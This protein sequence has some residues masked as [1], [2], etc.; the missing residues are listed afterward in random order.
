MQMPS[1]LLR[2]SSPVRAPSTSM[3][4]NI[5]TW[6]P[7]MPPH[8]AIQLAIGKAIRWLWTLSAS[9]IRAL[10]TFRVAAS[11]LP[12]PTWSKNFNWLMAVNAWLLPPLG[13]IRKFSRSL[14]PIRICT[15]APRPAIVPGTWIATRVTCYAPISL[16][17]HQN[18]EFGEVNHQVGLIPIRMEMFVLFLYVKDLV[19]SIKRVN[20]GFGGNVICTLPLIAHNYTFTIGFV[21]IKLLRVGNS[22]FPQGGVE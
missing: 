16:S 22:E 14:T 3:D 21:C 13:L 10:P 19:A 6:R 11:A 2:R 8:S 5:R 7:T 18:R 1:A 20:C 4:A 12:L 15:T 9:A 17:R